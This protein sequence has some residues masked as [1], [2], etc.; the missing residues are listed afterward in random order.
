MVCI[1]AVNPV[2][3]GS[4]LNRPHVWQFGGKMSHGKGEEEQ[5]ERKGHSNRCG[6]GKGQGGAK[7]CLF[8]TYSSTLLGLY[9]LINRGILNNT[10]M[11]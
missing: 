11:A 1:A 10:W 3:A 4:G 5:R 7:Q 9:M 6:G 8:V 2:R